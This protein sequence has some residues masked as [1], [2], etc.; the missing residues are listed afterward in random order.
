MKFVLP[1]FLLV[2][3]LTSQAPAAPLDYV[4]PDLVV[5]DIQLTSSEDKIGDESHLL[6]RVQNIGDGPTAK[7]A[8]IIVLFSV[9]GKSVA[10]S[11]TLR[12]S[13]AA[14]D[15][16]ILRSN[17]GPDGKGT[18]KVAPGTHELCAVVNDAG[19]INESKRTNNSVNLILKK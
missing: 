11:D 19:D 15:F 12:T 2:G 18:W 10:W 3:A 5:S 7:S 9:D 17:S 1:L 6:V 16:A 13:L 14:G 8:P 4:L